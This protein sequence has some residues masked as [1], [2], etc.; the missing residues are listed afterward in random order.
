MPR[1][2]PAERRSWL[3]RRHGVLSRPQ[4]L[5]LFAVLC[6][7]AATIGAVFLYWGYWPMLA[8][9]LLEMAVLGACLYQC[10]RHLD[11]YDRIEISEHS[12]LVEQRR[13]RRRSRRQL[14]LWSAR[15]LPTAHE[16]DPIRIN[17][18]SGITLALGRF[19]PTSQRRHLR[20]EI[21]NCLRRHRG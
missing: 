18:R 11:D 19:V 9:A 6:G 12:I 4:L 10:A 17:D 1:D 15:L 2:V 7:P 14:D 16:H 21:G 5:M 20:A 13:G 3:L 8:C